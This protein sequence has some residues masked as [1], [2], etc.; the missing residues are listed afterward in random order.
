M[1]D[2]P[3]LSVPPTG[4]T[5]AELRELERRIGERGIQLRRLPPTG[6]APGKNAE[7]LSDYEEAIIR[8]ALLTTVSLGVSGG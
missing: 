8:S 4:A 6:N 2:R 3:E 5:A 1:V 7:P